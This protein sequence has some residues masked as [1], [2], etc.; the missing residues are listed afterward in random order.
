MLIQMRLAKKNMKNYKNQ[1][2]KVTQIIRYF[3]IFNPC[4]LMTEKCNGM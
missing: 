4:I 1:V 3:R 2:L